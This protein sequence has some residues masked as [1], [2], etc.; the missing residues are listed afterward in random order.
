RG[1]PGENASTHRR[2]GIRMN[3]SIRVAVLALV[4]VVGAGAAARPGAG[5]AAAVDRAAP[6]A[7]TREELR[8]AWR[9][10]GKNAWGPDGLKPVSRTAHDWYGD[11]FLMTPVDALDT[12]LLLGLK[13]E[14]DK[15]K[16]L[17][18]ERLSFDRDVSVKNFEITIRLLG[19]LLS[20]HQATGDPRLLALA[21]D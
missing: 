18:L 11:S 17:I 1:H 15:A 4:A 13:D 5:P 21:D 16:A 10:Y 14:A 7:A 20:A 8:H 19:G 2:G 6:A 9:G 12:L 3:A